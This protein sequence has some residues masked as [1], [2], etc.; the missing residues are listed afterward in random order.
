MLLAIIIQGQCIKKGGV[1]VQSVRTENV[2]AERFSMHLN[3]GVPYASGHFLEISSLVFFL[4]FFLI[5]PCCI[6]ERRLGWPGDKSRDM[7]TS[8]KHEKQP[9][10]SLL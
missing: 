2:K 4:M 1:A 10:V 3:S 9:S 8:C 6:A 7:E 5:F